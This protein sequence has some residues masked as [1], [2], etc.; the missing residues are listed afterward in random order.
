MSESGSCY[1]QAEETGGFIDENIDLEGNRS[2]DGAKE[3]Q[4]EGTTQNLDSLITVFEANFDK[5]I[6]MDVDTNDHISN[7]S[8]THG[9]LNCNEDDE[10]EEVHSYLTQKH[11]L[12]NG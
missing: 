10:W 4:V 2:A 3:S 6:D 9:Q 11:T 7:R 12:P 1:N 5:T 8:E